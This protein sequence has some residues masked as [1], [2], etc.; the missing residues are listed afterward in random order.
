MG[1]GGLVPAKAPN[2]DC[3]AVSHGIS[4]VAVFDADPDMLKPGEPAWANYIKVNV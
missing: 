2:T 3:I 4:E 1:K